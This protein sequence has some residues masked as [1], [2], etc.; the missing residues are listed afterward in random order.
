LTHPTTKFQTTILWVTCNIF[1]FK[2]SHNKTRTNKT[3]KYIHS[4][5]TLFKKNGKRTKHNTNVQE[6]NLQL[7][8]TIWPIEGNYF[9][10]W[11]D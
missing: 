7:H 11:W 3:L 8:E 4:Q 2:V 10:M 6:I 1:Y 5:P 9:V